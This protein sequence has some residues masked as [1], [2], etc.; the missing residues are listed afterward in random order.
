M[1]IKQEDYQELKKS[2]DQSIKDNPQ[3]LELYRKNNLS[4]MRYRWD[5]FN[6]INTNL[7]N[8]YYSRKLSE[9]LTDDMIDTALRKITNTK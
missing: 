7:N 5:L 4:N 8:F 1:K 3:T 2:I 6:S 9:Y